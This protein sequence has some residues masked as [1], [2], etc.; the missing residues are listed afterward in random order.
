MSPLF[1]KIR[2]G[3]SAST[4]NYLIGLE[5]PPPDTAIYR[6]HTDLIPLADGGVTK[7]GNTWF[8]LSWDRLTTTQARVL[9]TI[10]D[11]DDIY[12]SV[13]KAWGAEGIASAW[14]DV[15]GKGSLSSVSVQGLI[16]GG[17]YEGIRL[18]VRKLITDNDPASF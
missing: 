6:D 3:N 13:N 14:I 15:H 17:M 2:L 10:A 9:R 5:I 8:R 4:M 7:R 1:Q 11:Y 18:E 16:G 12:A